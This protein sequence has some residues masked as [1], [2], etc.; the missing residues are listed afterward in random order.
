MTADTADVCPNCGDAYAEL[1]PPG[2]SPD[3]RGPYD[4]LCYIGTSE[5]SALAGY[6]VVHR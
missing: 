4:R 6:S 3:D 1:V 5:S 2:E